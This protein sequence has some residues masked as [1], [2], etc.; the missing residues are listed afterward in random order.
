MEQTMIHDIECER[1]LLGNLL[2]S[3]RAYDNENVAELLDEDCFYN[4]NCR[5]IYSAI[6]HIADRGDIPD[7]I[8]VSATIAKSGGLTDQMAVVNLMADA[9]STANIYNLA[10]RLKELKLRRKMW[11]LGHQLIVAG[12]T[13]SED[14][15]EAQ[16]TAK[17]TIESLFASNTAEVKSMTDTLSELREVIAYNRLNDR[18]IIGTPTGYSEI[19]KRGGLS[20]SDLVVVAG[21]TS[22]G[23]TAFATSM[24]VSAIANNH[25]VAFYSMEM[26]RLQLTARIAAMNSG[27]NSSTLLQGRLTD[28]Q[29]N[30]VEIGLRNINSDLLYFDDRSTSS[31]DSIL[32][33]I[34]TMKLKHNIAGAVVDYLQIL[35]VNTRNANVEQQLGEIAR[36]LK[37]IAKELNI[38]II[39][40]S[41]LSRDKDSP[42]PSLGRLRASGQIAEAADIVAL[43]Y[44]P[45]VYDRRYPAPFEQASTD[46]TAMIDIAKS[47]NI[48]CFK[49]LCGF[50]AETTQ[51]Y[52]LKEVPMIDSNS[53]NN[54]LCPF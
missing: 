33:S 2:L 50:R 44:R 40:L 51:F 22:Q 28:M 11:E 6:K 34:R 17:D 32:S 9:I 7:I 13:E 52:D 21:E 35:S 15:V 25:P 24:V 23:K 5:E 16:S 30:Q 4:L 8:S 37:N 31:I 43:V 53:N 26:S 49:F 45:S 46:G 36:R 14:I 48:G 47:R 19:D 3:F 27:V 1:Q 38:W 41:Q 10:L 54:T 12:S 20:P 18:P 42:V 39:A 29:T